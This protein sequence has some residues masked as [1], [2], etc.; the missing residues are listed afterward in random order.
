MLTP[1]TTTN[2]T[3]IQTMPASLYLTALCQW[4]CPSVSRDPQPPRTWNENLMTTQL[5]EKRGC[6]SCISSG[7]SIYPRNC[8]FNFT[9]QS[10]RL[11]SAHPS[12]SSL[13]QPPKK[14]RAETTMDSQNCRKHHWHQPAQPPVPAR[15]RTWAEKVTAD[16]SHPRHNLF[17]SS[18]LDNQTLEQFLPTRHHLN[19]HLISHGLPQ[20]L[21]TSN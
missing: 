15:L 9:L 6:A 11:F 2:A 3:G 18:P 21:L 12:L 8:W 5:S 10:L 17:H 1:S 20:S 7:S 19:E 16:P 14:R 13:V 4:R